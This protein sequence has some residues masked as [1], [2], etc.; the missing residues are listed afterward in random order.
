MQCSGR[1]ELESK[2]RGSEARRGVVESFADERRAPSLLR[3]PIP[4]ELHEQASR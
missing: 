3:C 1:A 2:E 4:D